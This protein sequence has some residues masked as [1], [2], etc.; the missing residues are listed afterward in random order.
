MGSIPTGIPGLGVL[1]LKVV[2]RDMGGTTAREFHCSG[3]CP[4]WIAREPK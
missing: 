1:N 2:D 4:A 3:S